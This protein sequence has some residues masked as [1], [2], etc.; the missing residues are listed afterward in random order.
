[1]LGYVYSS[2]PISADLIDIPGDEDKIDDDKKETCLERK[3]MLRLTRPMS[4][5]VKVG[6]QKKV[7]RM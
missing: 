4:M 1:M 6:I 5:V 3:W 7:L 2:Q